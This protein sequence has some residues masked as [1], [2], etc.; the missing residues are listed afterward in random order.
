M[1]YVTTSLRRWL[2]CV[3]LKLEEMTQTATVFVFGPVEIFDLD[4]DPGVCDFEIQQDL[5]LRSR[6]GAAL[7]DRPH[8]SDGFHLATSP[9][10]TTTTTCCLRTL[11][12][13]DVPGPDSCWR[14]LFTTR[15]EQSSVTSLERTAPTRP[16]GLHLLRR[17]R[18]YR[19]YKSLYCSAAAAVRY[20]DCS[21]ARCSDRRASNN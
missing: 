6:A 10:L 12:M 2:R 19:T 13:S 11:H 15:R 17:Y 9:L 16:Y 18:P 14:L 20:A 4:F 1:S 5:E 7:P 3:H 21:P 8:L